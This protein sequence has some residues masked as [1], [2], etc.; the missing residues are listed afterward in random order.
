MAAGTM[1]ANRNKAA[2][3][4]TFGI[5]TG[6]HQKLTEDGDKCSRGLEEN[7][8]VEIL[9]KALRLSQSRARV[10]ERRYQAL[11]K[12][13]DHLS[14][15]L[16]QESLRFLACRNTIRL[17]ELQASQLKST[18]AHHKGPSSSSSSL[19]WFMSRAFCVGI[20]C[21]ICLAFGCIYF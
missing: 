16:L 10:A 4:L 8:K 14:N 17:L 15:L 20:G 3:S 2:I 21:G 5:R 11:C 12:E 19:A 9:L 7:E 18:D 6:S 1:A 13:T